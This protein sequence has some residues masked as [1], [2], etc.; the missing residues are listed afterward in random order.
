MFETVMFFASWTT[1]AALML[2]AWFIYRY[3]GDL[4]L[5]IN[6]WNNIGSGVLFL[7]ASEIIRP[8]FMIERSLFWAYWLLSVAG[9]IMIAYGFYNLYEAEKV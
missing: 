3:S 2:V 1:A 4:G 6:Y 8:I 5:E 9:G 7:A